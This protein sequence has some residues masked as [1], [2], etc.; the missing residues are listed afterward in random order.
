MLNRRK[1]LTHSCSLGVAGDARNIGN[2]ALPEGRTKSSFV[3][4][5]SWKERPMPPKDKWG[6]MATDAELGLS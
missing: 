3:F 2:G 6:P 5:P 1:F 4:E